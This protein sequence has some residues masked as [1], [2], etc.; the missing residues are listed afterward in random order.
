MLKQTPTGQLVVTGEQRQQSMRERYSDGTSIQFR[1]VYF[2]SLTP[3]PE[4]ESGELLEIRC[5]SD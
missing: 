4:M 1:P 3:L 5:G 2:Q